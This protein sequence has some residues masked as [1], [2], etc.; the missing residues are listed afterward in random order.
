VALG[1]APSTRLHPDCDASNC[2]IDFIVI[3]LTL[4]PFLT[5]MRKQNLIKFSPCRIAVNE[6]ILV[7]LD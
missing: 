2:L 3:I 7:N 1:R 5:Y 4:K 6:A